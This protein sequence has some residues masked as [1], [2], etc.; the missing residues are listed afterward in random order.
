MNTEIIKYY[1][2]LAKNYD[3]DRFRN[4]YGKYI[5]YQEK[6]IVRKLIGNIDEDRILDMACG[7]GRFL[8]FAEYGIDISSEMINEA[9]LKYPRKNL[10]KENALNTHFEDSSFDTILSFHLF[11]HLN[12][13]TTEKLL[14]E[15]HRILKTG[16]KIIFDIPSKKRR[17]FTNYKAKNW[18]GANAFT[19]KEMSEMT[20]DKWRIKSYFGILFFPIHRGPQK[21][22]KYLLNLDILLCQSLMKEYSSYLIFSL[23]KI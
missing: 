6:T 9:K 11:M 4:T 5:D 23:E 16:G 19:V 8:E 2:D 15:A 18:H 21:I 3:K 14:D 13:E 1:D 17:I 22:R 10:F 12:R 7:T 20:K